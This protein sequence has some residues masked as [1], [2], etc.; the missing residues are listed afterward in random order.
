[1]PYYLIGSRRN[2]PPW[3]PTKPHVETTRCAVEARHDDTS[4]AVSLLSQ[5]LTDHHPTLSTIPIR[6]NALGGLGGAVGNAC[7]TAENVRWT[8]TL[9]CVRFSDDSNGQ[10]SAF[11]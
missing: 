10:H 5:K 1:M 3:N 7:G 11:P 8:D 2:P 9:V 4:A 6:S